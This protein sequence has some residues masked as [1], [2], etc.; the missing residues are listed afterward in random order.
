MKPLDCGKMLSV[1]WFDCWPRIWI[2]K[3]VVSFCQ[4]GTVTVKLHCWIHSQQWKNNVMEEWSHFVFVYTDNCI[5]SGKR[6]VTWNCLFNYIY[7]IILF[8]NYICIYYWPSVCPSG[9]FQLTSYLLKSL[10]LF[11]LSQVIIPSQ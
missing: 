7:W 5:Q 9:H 4:T 6:H 2:S 3:S 10:F 8:R 1:K 11:I